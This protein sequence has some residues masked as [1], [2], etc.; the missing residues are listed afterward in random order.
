MKLIF[1]ANRIPYPPFR[2]D[3]LKIYN[4]A[5]CL[6]PNH[7]LHLVTFYETESELQY[8]T[9]L[10]AVFKSVT[11]IRLSKWRCLVQTALTLFL[12][13]TPFQVGY[14]RSK[15]FRKTLLKR[16]DQIQPD[17]I[18]VQHLRMAQQIPKEYRRMALL[19]LPDAIS[20][21]YER[22]K[23]HS[24]SPLQKLAFA[25]ETHRLKRYEHKVLTEFPRVLCCSQEDALHLHN[26]HPKTQISILENGVDTETFAPR[27]SP[28]TPIKKLLFTGNMNFAPN[29]DAVEYFAQDIFPAIRAKFPEVVFEIAGGKPLPQVQSLAQIPG[30][31]VSGFIPN[32]ADAYATATLV[33]APLRFGAGTQNKVLEALS[34]DIPVVC[35]TIGF[36][37]LGL[38]HGEGI[39]CEKSTEDFITRIEHALTQPQSYKQSAIEAGKTISSRF[40]W[41]SIAKQLVH[42]FLEIN[43]KP[44]DQKK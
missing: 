42:Y 5:R 44:T 23:N 34:M 43:A 29:V 18:H 25:W 2:G 7:E 28:Q 10:N 17:G 8:E 32:L 26:L 13:Y 38:K 40:N 20:M 35:S 30:V 15:I 12:P 31:V 33:V 3:K 36:H 24:R 39:W 22:R 9:A 16:L 4:L 19:D 11:L 37:G 41:Q 1:V 21:Y 14:F 27:N 6:S